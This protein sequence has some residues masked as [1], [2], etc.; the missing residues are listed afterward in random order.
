MELLHGVLVHSQNWVGESPEAVQSAAG[1]E[2]PGGRQTHS[3]ERTLQ[4]LGT[5][6]C[7]NTE[8]LNK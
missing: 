3:W 7:G 4:D 2:A 8:I 6:Q 1:G 5:L